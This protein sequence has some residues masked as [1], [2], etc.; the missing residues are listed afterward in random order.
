MNVETIAFVGAGNLAT[1]LAQALSKAGHNV[2]AI[3][4]PS[5]TSAWEL[6]QK[7][8]D[9]CKA[10]SNLEEL[11]LVD[12]YILAV[13]DDA[14]PNVVA[15]WPQHCKGGVVAHTA[16]SIPMDALASIGGDYGVFYPLQT[17]SK[18]RKL[19]F[20]TIPCFIEANSEATSQRLLALARTI[21]NAVKAL[22]SDGRAHLHLSA[23]FACNFVNHLYDV[24]SQLLANKG[25]APKW[26]EPLIQETAAKALT[27]SPRKAQTG[28]AVRG[29]KGVMEK[30]LSRLAD[31]PEWQEIYALLSNSIYQT[32]HP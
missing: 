7:I 9:S 30:H 13:S 20:S 2:K 17:F 32:F 5:G 23:V 6:A 11:P 28:P 26:L 27:L 31:T 21:S 18:S 25:V 16:G 4:S 8:G 10:V 19:N 15:H 22:D 1:H 29:D 3:Y 12:I 24:S 14:L